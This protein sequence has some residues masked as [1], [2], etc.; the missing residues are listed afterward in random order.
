MLSKAINTLLLIK[1]HVDS[2]RVLRQSLFTRCRLS[3]LDMLTLTRLNNIVEL[4]VAALLL[5]I[6]KMVIA[7]DTHQ[8]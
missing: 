1:K 3:H 7:L 6:V 8:M 2:V 4:T 5:L